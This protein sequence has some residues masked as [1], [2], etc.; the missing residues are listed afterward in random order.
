MSTEE[1]K[2]NDDVLTWS[3]NVRTQGNHC[4]TILHDFPF[5]SVVD[6]KKMW[7]CSVDRRS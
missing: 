1:A 7:L 5:F 3:G 6:W 2:Y 4:S